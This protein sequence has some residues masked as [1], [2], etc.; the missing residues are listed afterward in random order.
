VVFTVIP[1]QHVRATAVTQTLRPFFASG[2]N[3]SM[4]LGTAGSEDAVIL[5]GFVDNVLSAAALIAAID[6]PQKEREAMAADRLRTMEAR[7]QALEARL[8]ALEGKAPAK[9]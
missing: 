5:S 6:V 4:S 1:V 7:V 8:A 2:G 3:Q 9:N